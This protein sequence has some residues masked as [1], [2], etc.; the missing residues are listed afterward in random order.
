[1]RYR[2]LLAYLAHTYR[3]SPV[4]G[5][6][7]ARG[8]LLQRVFAEMFNVKAIAEILVRLPL[9]DPNAPERAGPTFEMPY[10]TALPPDEVDCW[11]LYR[12]VLETAMTLSRNLLDTAPTGTGA[13]YLRALFELDEGAVSWLDARISSPRRQRLVRA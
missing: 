5:H 7:G 4:D 13:D 2:L 9:G 11:R 12:D 6:G 3:L 1:V 10:T 8:A